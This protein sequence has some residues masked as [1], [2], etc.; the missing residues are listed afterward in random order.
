MVVVLSLLSP[1]T[2]ITNVTNFFRSVLDSCVTVLVDAL[3][4][5]KPPHHPEDTT[6]TYIERH[7]LRRPRGTVILP[8]SLPCSRLE[9]PLVQVR[10]RIC[11]RMCACRL[12]FVSKTV[13]PPYWPSNKN[14]PLCLMCA[15]ACVSVFMCRHECF[16]LPARCC[17]DHDEVLPHGRSDRGWIKG[18]GG[19]LQEVQSRGGQ[20][21]KALLY[22]FFAI[23]RRKIQDFLFLFF[24]CTTTD[25]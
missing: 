19:E 11:V 14:T 10:A 23:L 2:D 21:E 25:V 13:P 17:V 22:L 8:M 18:H 4:Y 1:T 6:G 9:H 15:R 20:G 5:S 24:V 7:G 16:F 3:R 12:F